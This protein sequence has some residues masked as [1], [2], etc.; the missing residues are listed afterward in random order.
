MISKLA[1]VEKQ[2]SVPSALPL[3]RL[4]RCHYRSKQ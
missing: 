3:L 4:H 1:A 2:E